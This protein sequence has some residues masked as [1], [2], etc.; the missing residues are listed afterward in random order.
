[1]VYAAIFLLFALPAMA[2]FTYGR[3]SERITVPPA[4]FEGV[5][6]ARKEEGAPRPRQTRPSF[7]DC[8]G[9]GNKDFVIYAF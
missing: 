1:M 4:P 3:I 8:R 9:T 7:S 5:P 6:I 2:A